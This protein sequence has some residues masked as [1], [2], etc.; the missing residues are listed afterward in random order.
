MSKLNPHTTHRLVSRT[1]WAWL[2]PILALSPLS[3]AAKG[4]S[5]SGVVGD[6]CPTTKECPPGGTAGTG[7]GNPVGTTCGGLLGTGCADGAFCDFEISAMCGAADQTGV[8]TA[9]PEACT[10]IYA[11]VCGCDG[12]TYGSDCAAQSAGV[13]VSSKGECGGSGTGG[14]T[15]TGGTGSGGGATCGGL[16]GAMCPAGQYCDF[17]LATQCGSGDQTGTCAPKPEVCTDIYQ[18]VCGCDGNTYGNDCDAAGAGISVAKTGACTGGGTACGTRGGAVCATDEYCLYEVG[19]D[20]GRADAP[21]TCTKLPQAGACDAIFAPVCGCDGKT[22]SN[23]CEAMMAAASIDHT[24]ACAS[25]GTCGGLLGSQCASGYF[26]NFPADMAC[27]NADGTGDC[28][29]IPGACTDQLDPVCGC[30]GKPYGN[31]C[32]ANA[33]GVSVA[34]K[35]A[36]K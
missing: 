1:H 25:G 23:D 22:Y 6:D 26:C 21:G 14:S 8:C 28:T 29:A 20:C 10:T 17:P 7:S 35:G 31:P 27:G 12:K 32:E 2:L 9:K 24:G 13:S 15:G 34:Y 4:C 36:C 30:D 11:P 18:P 19:D 16:L 5:N 3:L 33:K